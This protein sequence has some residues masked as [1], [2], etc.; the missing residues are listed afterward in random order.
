MVG[1][2]EEMNAAAKAREQQRALRLRSGFSA[3]TSE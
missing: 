3:V 1:L 2:A